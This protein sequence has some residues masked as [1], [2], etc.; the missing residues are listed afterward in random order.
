MCLVTKVANVKLHPLQFSESIF[1]FLLAGKTTAIMRMFLTCISFCV[2]TFSLGADITPGLLSNV[3][4]LAN[5]KTTDKFMDQHTWSTEAMDITK[6]S[7]ALPDK[8]F[9]IKTTFSQEFPFNANSTQILDEL[10]ESTPEQNS[11]LVL[12]A[13][14]TE[15]V[16]PNTTDDSTGSFVQF[17]NVSFE[18]MEVKGK[19]KNGILALGVLVIL[20]L[21]WQD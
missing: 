21:A 19:W 1:Q 2:Y 15:Y 12:S 9:D 4:Q 18:L 16:A 14:V 11:S 8:V 20:Q 7:T 17:H 5:T 3:S 13:P 10:T 6:D